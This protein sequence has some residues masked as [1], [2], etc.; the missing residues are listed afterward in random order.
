MIASF[1]YVKMVVNLRKCEQQSAFSREACNQCC[2]HRCGL[3][4]VRPRGGIPWRYSWHAPKKQSFEFRQLGIRHLQL[5]YT[6]VSAASSALLGACAKSHWS[7]VHWLS[8]AHVCFGIWLVNSRLRLHASIAHTCN[9][10]E[11]IV[12][13]FIGCHPRIRFAHP[14]AHPS[15]NVNRASYNFLVIHLDTKMA[16]T[17]TLPLPWTTYPAGWDWSVVSARPFWENGKKKYDLLHLGAGHAHD[18]H[19]FNQRLSPSALLFMRQYVIRL[20]FVFGTIISHSSSSCACI[21]AYSLRWF[22]CKSWIISFGH[23]MHI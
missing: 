11:K 3:H 10:H 4:R 13:T 12:R 17:N 7:H 16:V 14:H 6:T 5:L 19:S 9:C 20:T 8:F 23:S 21:C 2:L 15:T 1:N 18:L 22:V